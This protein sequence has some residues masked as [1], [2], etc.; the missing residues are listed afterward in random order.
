MLVGLLSDVHANWP[1]L[2][3]ALEALERRGVEEL[4]VAG[5]LV[6]YGGQP[7]ECVSALREAGARCVAG[8]HDLFV[9]GRLPE[10]R[11][12]PLARRCAEVT[13]GLLA[14]ETRDYLGT[15]P[16]QLRTGD[17]L[18]AHGSLDSPEEYVTHRGRALELLSRLPEVA[19]GATTLVLGHTHAQWCV[20]P[21]RGVR[22]RGTVQLPGRPRLVNPGSV[23]QS[24]QRERRPRVRFAV[25]DTTAST[26]E[27]LTTEYDVQASLEVLR[28]LGLPDRCVH[29]PLAPRDLARSTAGRLA[30]GGSGLRRSRRT[31][32]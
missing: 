22:A 15:L 29:A 3:A 8:N 14:S 27:F 30:L 28:G 7:N 1:A 24:R 21:G 16:L 25:H 17:V 19:P 18:M 5:D 6:D 9:L 2:R 31:S 20:V 13:R 23:G 11:F 4:L 10:T 26:V 32:R 12:P